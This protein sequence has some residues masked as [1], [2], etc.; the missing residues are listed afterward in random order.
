VRGVAGAGRIGGVK[1]RVFSLGSSLSSLLCVATVALWVLS[2]FYTFCMQYW[3]T[4]VVIIT[5]AGGSVWI[6]VGRGADINLGL[7]TVA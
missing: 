4:I 2:F 5:S 3:G 1:R 7:L 6:Q